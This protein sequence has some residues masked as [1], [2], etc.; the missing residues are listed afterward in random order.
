MIDLS[1]SSV[2]AIVSFSPTEFAFASIDRNVIICYSPTDSLTDSPDPIQKYFDDDLPDFIS[3]E[4]DIDIYENRP[5]I[6]VSILRVVHDE[7]Y[8]DDDD[9]EPRP[10]SRPRRPTY[11]DDDDYS[12]FERNFLRD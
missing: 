12:A 1:K 8:Y 6:V 7:N 10:T 5:Y 2:A 4:L 3:H 9:L 11:N